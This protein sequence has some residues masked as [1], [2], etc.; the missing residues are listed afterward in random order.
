ML[1]TV[2]H[3]ALISK[4]GKQELEL[5]V[6]DI[7]KQRMK[8]C[9]QCLQ[10]LFYVNL[11]ELSLKCEAEM[12]DIPAANWWSAG[13]L[14]RLDRMDRQGQRVAYDVDVLQSSQP[15]PPK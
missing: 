11:S 5:Y 12:S 14:I 6:I 15:R 13:P 2:L 3:E 10:A 9:L 4:E 8:R 7:V 1:C